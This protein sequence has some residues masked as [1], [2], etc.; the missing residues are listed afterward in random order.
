MAKAEYSPA[1]IGHFGLGFPH[2]AHF[3]SPIRR[4]PDVIVHR[5]LKNIHR[6]QPVI[7]LR[8]S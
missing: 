6:V 7:T 8:L 1:N 2:Y 5:L 4:Y 3:T